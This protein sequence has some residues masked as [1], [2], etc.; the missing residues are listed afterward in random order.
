MS[1][2]ERARGRVEEIRAKGVATYLRELRGSNAGMPQI[3][4]IKEIREK[5]LL[6]VLEERV[7]RVR[8]IRERGIL[9]RPAVMP[10]PTPAP[11]T[12]STPPPAPQASR[13]GVTAS[14]QEVKGEGAE[15]PREAAPPEARKEIRSELSVEI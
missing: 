2:I 6:W 7:P 12:P 1:L 9:A 14:P 11:P 10:P 8:E 13:E 4:T 5:G 15:P 3:P